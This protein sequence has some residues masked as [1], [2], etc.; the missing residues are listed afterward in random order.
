MKTIKAFIKSRPVISYFALTFAI[1]W[2]GMLLIMVAG[3]AGGIPMVAWVAGPPRGSHPVDRP[4][5]RKGRL[6]RP[7]L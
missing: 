4:R 5:L 2:G 7:P 3:G 1:S 6:S